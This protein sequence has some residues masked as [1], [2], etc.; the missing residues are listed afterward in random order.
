MATPH[1]SVA[2][3]R[4]ARQRDGISLGANTVTVKE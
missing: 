4:V 3:E 1:R 2:L